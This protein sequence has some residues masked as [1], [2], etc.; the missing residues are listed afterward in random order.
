[1][2]YHQI[3][4]QSSI[5][6][7]HQRNLY[8]ELTWKLSVKVLFGKKLMLSYNLVFKCKP[9]DDYEKSYG[10]EIIH[11]NFRT[12]TELRSNMIAREPCFKIDHL[13]A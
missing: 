8:I 6:S 5:N 3:S 13:V 7:G 1:M 2:N 12:H 4:Y 10:T 9:G 11:Q